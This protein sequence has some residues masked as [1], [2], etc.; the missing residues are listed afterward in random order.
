MNDLDAEKDTLDQVTALYDSTAPFDIKM[1][2]YMMRTIKPY[3]VEGNCLQVG[4]SHGD[5]TSLLA[6][7]FDDITVVEAAKEFIEWTEK[8]TREKGVNVHFVQS[9]IETYES[10]RLFDN[11]IFTHVLEHVVHPVAVL[12]KLGSLLSPNGRLFTIVPN[13]QAAS[14]QIAVKMGVLSHLEAL[15]DADINGGHKR[16]YFSDTLIRDCKS[17]N[18]SVV[19]SGG[20]FFKPLANFQFDKLIGGPLISDAFMEGCFELGRELPTLSASIFTIC[21]RT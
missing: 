1:R 11:I 18:L 4:C 16:V 21:E 20:I 6:D 3:L 7:Y 13:G 19:H 8:R 5:Q 15:S 9:M 10:D 17:A 2:D 14:R 12:E